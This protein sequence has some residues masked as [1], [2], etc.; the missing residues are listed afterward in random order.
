MNDGAEPYQSVDLL[1][2]LRNALVHHKPHEAGDTGADVGKRLRKLV[3][4][5]K[6]RITLVIMACTNAFHRLIYV[7]SFCDPY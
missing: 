4:G 2:G 7:D 6:S 1:V 3:D 5:L